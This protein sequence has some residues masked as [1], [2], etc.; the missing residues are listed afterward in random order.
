WLKDTGVIERSPTEGVK[1][2]RRQELA[3]KTLARSEIRKLLRECEARQ[4]LRA[5]AIFCFLLYTGCRVSE[6][7]GLDLTD[8]SL[9]ERSGWATFRL[10][11]GGKQRTVPL[12]LA[13]RRSIEPYLRAPPPL[14]TSKLFVGERGPLTPRGVRAICSKYSAISGVRIHTHLMRHV[15]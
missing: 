15:F 14:T 3:P 5:T 6:L 8:V 4:D 7:V 11:R 1:E 2:L 10:A 13:A 12:L 9:S